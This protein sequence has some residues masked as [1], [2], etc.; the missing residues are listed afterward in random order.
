MAGHL[1]HDHA[2]WT[3]DRLAQDEPDLERALRQLVDH[4]PTG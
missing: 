1:E 4:V 2:H 3:S